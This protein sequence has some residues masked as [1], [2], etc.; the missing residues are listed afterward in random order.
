MRTIDHD[1]Y[2]EPPEDR[3]PAPLD[4]D[5]ERIPPKLAPVADDKRYGEGVI[6]V[7]LG[8]LLVDER[9]NVRR[10]PIP[11]A[12]QEGLAEDI[13]RTGLLEPLVVRPVLVRG[14]RGPEE[15]L[16][17]ISGFRRHDAMLRILGWEE[18]PAMV[19]R[20]TEAEALLA[21]L[22]EN[23]D[24]ED[25]H[26]FD[27]ARRLVDLQDAFG[28]TSKE[29]G[30]RSNLSKGHVNNLLRVLRRT[31]PDILGA[32]EGHMASETGAVALRF[33]IELCVETRP[34]QRRIFRDR[35]GIEAL[36]YDPLVDDAN[37]EPEE[38]GTKGRRGRSRFAK[39]RMV[40]QLLFRD[41][42]KPTPGLVRAGHD[43]RLAGFP[44]G[45]N[46]L[47]DRDRKIARMVL[48]YVLRID[49]ACYP[50]VDRSTYES[51]KPKRTD[52][53]DGIGGPSTLRQDAADREDGS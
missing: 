42:K 4:P 1:P 52:N 18:A 10:R 40:E 30:E 43:V 28:L 36:P 41:L 16:S 49:G 37:Y 24:R 12:K 27:V 32:I 38:E 7:R 34:D 6:L 44:E 15:R 17:V 31:D 47:T 45:E 14:A 25:L 33:V 2:D 53:G 20:C 22:A 19:R 21:N 50:V 46:V 39:R 26:P 29:L 9:F 11:E 13:R 23:T 48:R 8:A 51:E 35:Y 5:D 3:G